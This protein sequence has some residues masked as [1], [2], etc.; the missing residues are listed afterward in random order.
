MT[1]GRGAATG[2]LLLTIAS[3]IASAGPVDP[4]GRPLI[5]K[6]G[7]IDCD[8]VETTPV[9]FHERLYRCEWVRTSY[10]GNLLGEN[11]SRLVEVSTGKAT[12]PFAKGHV[13]SS[14][15]VDGDTIYVTATSTEKGWTGQ[16]VDVF[17]S[18]DLQRWETWTALDLPGFEIC[19]T[20]LCQTPD[21]Y[22]LMFEIGK[23]VEEAGAAFTAR[24]AT[25]KDLRTWKVTPP[26]CVYA[27][28]RYTAPHCLRYLDGY[29]HDFYLEAHEGYEM[30]VVRSRDLVHWEPSPLN[31]V[32]KAS[33][34]DKQIAN[35]QLTDEQRQRIAKARNI[36]NSDID[37]CQ[38]EGRLVI[39]YSWGN[40]QG[41]EFLAAAVY[42][43]TV[44][45]FLQGWFPQ[46]EHVAR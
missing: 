23:P 28:D 31:P 18:K 37:F 27:K 4:Q 1:R 9:V 24:F 5:R 21:Q 3:G 8:L 32:L 39:N 6:L 10:K 26:E 16:R 34:Q 41:E 13:F 42:D 22:V 40:Q 15:F 44:E 19:N 38:Y 2:L 29:Y 25:S 11:Y 33:A 46:Q 17:A 36:N 30:R 14:A 20:S 35:P 7:T 12:E 45:D 43:G